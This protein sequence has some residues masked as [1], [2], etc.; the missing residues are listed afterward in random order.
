[1]AATLAP[2]QS[3]FRLAAAAP[4]WMMKRV[5]PPSLQEC[6]PNIWA[7]AVKR[8][9]GLPDGGKTACIFDACATHTKHQPAGAGPMAAVHRLERK[10]EAGQPPQPSEAYQRHAFVGNALTI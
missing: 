4:A 5:A 8:C 3:L 7:E 2:G 9:N 10:F 1:M 6:D